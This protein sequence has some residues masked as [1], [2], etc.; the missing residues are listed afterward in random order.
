MVSVHVCEQL[1]VRRVSQE[2]Q[3]A[4]EKTDLVLLS[5]QRITNGQII[6]WSQA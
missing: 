4:L 5:M 2:W 3:S 1:L 6:G